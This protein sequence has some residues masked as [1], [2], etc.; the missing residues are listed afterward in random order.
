MFCCTRR[1]SHRGEIV[2]TL[3]Q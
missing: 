1:E 2:T 3:C